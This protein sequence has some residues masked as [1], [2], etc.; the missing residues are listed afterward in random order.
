MRGVMSGVEQRPLTF[1]GKF[2]RR[3]WMVEIH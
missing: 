3:F 1:F 2:K